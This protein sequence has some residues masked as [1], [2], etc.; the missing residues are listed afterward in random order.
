M[1]R[2]MKGVGLGARTD[3]EGKLGQLWKKKINTAKLR[4]GLKR[5]TANQTGDRSP[6]K[7]RPSYDVLNVEIADIKI[8]GRRRALNP[9][10]IDELAESISSLGLQSPITA[11]WVKRDLGW[12]K[13]KT[14]LVLVSGLHRLEAV[15]QLGKTTIPCVILK[16]GKRIARMWEISENLHCAE[17][18][19]FEHDEQVAEW[20]RLTQAEQAISGQTVQKRVEAAGR[21]ASRRRRVGCRSQGR[22]TKRSARTSSVRL[23]SIA[24][25]RKPRTRSRRRDSIRIARNIGKSQP[26]G[27]LRHSWRR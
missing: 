23:S 22:A 27:H 7:R 25:F 17:L 13:T 11:R 1:K 15:K 8:T 21:A 3:G 18:T 16:G 19:P 12:G 14:E 20:V 26:K 24:S 9:A 5:S 2:K 10:K 4:G 6:V